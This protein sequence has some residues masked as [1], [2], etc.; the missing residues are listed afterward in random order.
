MTFAAGMIS[1]LRVKENLY[2]SF[3]YNIKKSKYDGSINSRNTKLRFVSLHDHDQV[4]TED[5][6]L[7]SVNFLF[8]K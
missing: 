8:R 6:C 3:Q 1:A 4:V 2:L 7:L 5:C